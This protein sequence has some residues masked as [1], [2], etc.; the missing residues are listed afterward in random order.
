M[1]LMPQSNP[2]NIISKIEFLRNLTPPL[3]YWLP[4]VS[5]RPPG[6]GVVGIFDSD[7]EDDDFYD[8]M[9]DSTS[10]TQNQNKESSVVNNNGTVESVPDIEEPPAPDSVLPV[11]VKVGYKAPD[12]D[13]PK[14]TI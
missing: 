14:G 3:Y 8:A 11:S 1:L 9:D 4:F 12:S 2:Y 7:E 10:T 13:L 6:E 5:D